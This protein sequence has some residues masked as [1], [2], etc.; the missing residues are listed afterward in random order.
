MRKIILLLGLLFCL[1]ALLA[2]GLG[3][4][5]FEGSGAGGSAPVNGEDTELCLLESP[6]H[7]TN[8]FCWRRDEATDM[9]QNVDAYLGAIG[10]PSFQTHRISIRDDSMASGQIQMVR[11][12]N[13]AIQGGTSIITGD[14]QLRHSQGCDLVAVAFGITIEGNMDSVD[15]DCRWR[16]LYDTDPTTDTH[17]GVAGAPGG[18]WAYC[19]ENIDTGNA[20]TNSYGYG[21]SDPLDDVGEYRVVPL[22]SCNAGL[23]PMLLVAE[24]WNGAGSCEEVNSVQ[25]TLWTVEDCS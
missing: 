2:V 19:T 25:A 11:W 17:S 20:S 6:E 10:V 3:P 5:L 21:T 24:D 1:P 4:G 8:R 7:G 16:V 15:E 22:S 12:S 18:T 9:T 14:V 23:G 13:N